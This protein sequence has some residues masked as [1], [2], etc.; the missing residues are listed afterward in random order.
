M[1]CGICGIE[2]ELDAAFIKQ[3]RSIASEPKVICPNCWVKGNNSKHLGFLVVIAIGGV[4]GFLL[5]WVAPD[6]FAGQLLVTSF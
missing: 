6:N 1:K 2:S 5:H 4:C 3:R